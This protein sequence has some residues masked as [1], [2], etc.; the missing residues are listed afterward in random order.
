MTGETLCG[1]FVSGSHDAP[2]AIRRKDASAMDDRRANADMSAA[3]HLPPYGAA[4]ARPRPIAVCVFCGDVEFTVSHE[5]T[6]R[7]LRGD[8]AVHVSTFDAAN[9]SDDHMSCVRVNGIKMTRPPA[10]KATAG[11][12][13]PEYTNFI[14][15]TKLLRLADA[16]CSAAGAENALALEFA[17]RPKGLNRFGV[18]ALVYTVV[19]KSKLGV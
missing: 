12:R 6:A 11:I 9:G 19:V 16:R 13:A 5:L 18:C 15:A 2:R 3:V 8:I 10:I 14:D 17:S 7:I 4:N 1:L